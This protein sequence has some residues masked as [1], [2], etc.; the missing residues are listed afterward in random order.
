MTQFVGHPEF[1]I[2]CLA[3]QVQIDPRCHGLGKVNV[4]RIFMLISGAP[5]N[6]YNEGMV[7]VEIRYKAFKGDLRCPGRTD[8]LSYLFGHLMNVFILQV[9]INQRR[10]TRETIKGQIGHQFF[11]KRTHVFSGLDI[12]L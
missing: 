4:Q 8:L 5:K 10:G 9:R 3:V 7:L 12:V 1:K 2:V 6:R 11:Q